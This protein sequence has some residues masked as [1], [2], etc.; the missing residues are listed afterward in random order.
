MQIVSSLHKMSIL[1]FLE[2]KKN[3]TNLSPAELA[4]RV[5]KVTVKHTNH[6]YGYDRDKVIRHYATLICLIKPCLKTY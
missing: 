6:E 3:V 2:N 5:A 4:Q 1:F